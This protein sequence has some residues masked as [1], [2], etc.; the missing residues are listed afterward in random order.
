MRLGGEIRTSKV[1]GRT[2]PTASAS[3][4]RSWCRGRKQS[5]PVSLQPQLLSNG[6]LRSTICQARF[7]SIL[8]QLEREHKYIQSINDTFGISDQDTT[9]YLLL[10]LMLPLT[11]SAVWG[12]GAIQRIHPAFDWSWESQL[13]PQVFHRNHFWNIGVQ[14]HLTPF[15]LRLL[16]YRLTDWL[17]PRPIGVVWTPINGYRP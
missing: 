3:R 15:L 2:N 16:S 12:C 7:E 8:T 1:R 17:D 5:N 6:T 9:A 11:T 4:K 13:E 14:C 10:N